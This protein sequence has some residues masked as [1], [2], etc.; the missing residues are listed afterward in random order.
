MNSKLFTL[1]AGLFLAITILGFSDFQQSKDWVAPPSADELKNPFKG[2][3]EATQKGKKLYA[4]LCAVCHGNKGKGD[5]VAGAALNPQPANFTSDK[6]K[7]Q[8]DGALYWKI[9]EGR[10]PMAS[11]KETLTDEERWQ[12]VNYIRELE[13]K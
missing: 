12:L 3:M 11:Y 8:S 1:V 5:G 9:T 4:K 2:D 6:V 10:P 13:K 7:S